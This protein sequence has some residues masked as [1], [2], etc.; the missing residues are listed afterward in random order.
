MLTVYKHP[1]KILYVYFSLVQSAASRY[2][3]YMRK[4]YW[5][6]DLKMM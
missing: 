3:P 2:L 4:Y 1:Q 6:K 5:M